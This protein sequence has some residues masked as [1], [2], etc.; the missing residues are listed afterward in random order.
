[1]RIQV[2]IQFS[3]KG[4]AARWLAKYYSKLY[5]LPK[6]LVDALH[7]EFPADQENA[8]WGQTIERAA[9]ALLGGNRD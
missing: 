9:L 3:D 8:V 4:E 6:G 7:E 2:D 1:M 5:A